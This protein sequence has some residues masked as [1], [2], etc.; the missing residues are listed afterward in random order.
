MTYF[1]EWK[2][3][4]ARIEGVLQA[5]DLHSRFLS[6]RS[7]DSYGRTGKLREQLAET[8]SA[9]RTYR[10]THNTSLPPIVR[11]AVDRF[12]GAAETLITDTSGTPDSREERVWAA[13]VMFGILKAE[14]SYLLSDT[15]QLVRSRA[16]RAFEHLQRSIVA[17]PD[18]R[19]KWQMAF[20]K[21]ETDCE[22]LGSIQLLM[23]GIWAFKANS[24]GERTDLLFRNVL[25]DARPIETAADGLVLTEWKVAGAKLDAASAYKAALVQAQLYS[26]GSLAGLELTSHRYLVVM[27]EMR[28]APPAD[29]IIGEVTYRHINIAV[30]PETP[31]KASAKKARRGET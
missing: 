26:Q 15:Q 2:F 4:S 20:E 10:V 7:S 18:I 17:D 5:G 11:M 29:K 28:A 25:S 21:G 23:H 8:F 3:L 13:L 1:D 16:E 9:L 27:S 19:K 6:I 24:A 14:V 22:A 31:S 30:A 12:L